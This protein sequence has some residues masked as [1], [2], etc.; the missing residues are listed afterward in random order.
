MLN[1]GRCHFQCDLACHCRICNHRYKS[2]RLYIQHH[3]E[4]HASL[5][6]HCAACNAMLISAKSPETLAHLTNHYI[7]QR[8]D[9]PLF[10]CS[11][12]LYI[13]ALKHLDDYPN[14][15]RCLL[16]G[17]GSDVWSTKDLVR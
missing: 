14:E 12:S 17:D 15:L 3:L 5:P 10:S 1:A 11:Q 9:I 7:D 6:I 8:R 4:K 16:C 13:A 2:V